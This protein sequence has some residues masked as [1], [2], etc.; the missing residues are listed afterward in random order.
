MKTK[1]ISIVVVVLLVGLILPGCVSKTE[2]NELKALVAEQETLIEEQA[3]QIA[4]LETLIAKQEDQIAEQEAEIAGLKDEIRAKDAQIA[5]LKE[6]K[7]ELQAEIDK[8]KESISAKI[9]ITFSTNPVPCEN[10]Y[11]DWRI[12]YTEV[13][14]IGLT[15]EDETI[16]VYRNSSLLTTYDNG[17]YYF[18]GKLPDA[19]LPAY[20]SVDFGGHINCQNITH[21]IFTATGVDD[22]GNKITVT[23]R[24]DVER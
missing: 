9:E 20:G 21:F 24:V 5:E 7:A 16:Y 14:G 18:A 12:T 13:N 8:L 10:G 23:G 1:I 3:G 22:N 2:Y 4:E 11:W 15:F 17:V 19:Y 6:E